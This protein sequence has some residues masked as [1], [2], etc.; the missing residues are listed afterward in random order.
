MK[1]LPDPWITES[2]DTGAWSVGPPVV[3]Y[4]MDTKYLVFSKVFDVSQYEISVDMAK[5]WAR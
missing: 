3:S 2:M 1:Q 4:S 5:M